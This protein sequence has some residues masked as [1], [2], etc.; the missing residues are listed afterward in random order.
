MLGTVDDPDDAAAQAVGI[1]R[2]QAQQ[3]AVAEAGGFAGLGLARNE[4]AD[5]G[6]APS[7]LVPFVGRGDQVAVGVAAVTSA[8]TVEGRAP[9]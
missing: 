9:G 5:R 1:V 8:S 7:G 3:H 4:D 6:V 2:R